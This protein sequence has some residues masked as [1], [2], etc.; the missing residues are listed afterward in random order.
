MILRLKL[1]RYLIQTLWRDYYPVNSL[2]I[3][4]D[5]MLEVMNDDLPRK[6]KIKGF[7]TDS[8]LSGEYRK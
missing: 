8:N 7:K 4:F 2:R 6:L 1:I 5:D 3:G